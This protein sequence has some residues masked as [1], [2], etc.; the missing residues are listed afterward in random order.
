MIIY[1][2]SYHI[3]EYFFNNISYHII[4]T[5]HIKCVLRLYAFET[6]HILD[7]VVQMPIIFN[8]RDSFSG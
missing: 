5:Y 6:M 2:T 1:S 8:T 4:K 7:V 3:N